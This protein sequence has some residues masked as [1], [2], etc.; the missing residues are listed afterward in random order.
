[1]LRAATAAHGLHDEQVSQALFRRQRCRCS[2]VN[3][4]LLGCLSAVL[5]R[6]RIAI[7]VKCQVN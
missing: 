6:A 2:A 4:L 3:L 1:V 7:R 5:A